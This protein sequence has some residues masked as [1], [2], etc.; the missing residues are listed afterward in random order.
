M[1]SVVL[2]VI[3][4]LTCERW[5]LCNS[6]AVVFNRRKKSTAFGRM[7]ELAFGVYCL[8]SFCYVTSCYDSTCSD[9]TQM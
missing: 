3:N 6:K 7:A 2:I 1:A 4:C 5:L 8:R 9:R